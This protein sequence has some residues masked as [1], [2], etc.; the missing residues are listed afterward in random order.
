MR[1]G[2]ALAL[3]AAVSCTTLVAAVAT[4]GDDHDGVVSSRLP[5]PKG[6]YVALGDS[7]TA[8]PKVPSQNEKPAGCG[9]SDQ[10]YPALVAEGLGLEGAGFRDVSCSGATIDDLFAPQSTDHGANPAQLS[11]V[12]AATQMITLGIG[13]NDIGFS[14]MI[15]KCVKAGF[16]RQLEKRVGDNEANDAPCRQDYVF[17]DTDAVRARIHVVGARIS[18]VLSDIERLA[19]RAQVYVVGYPSTLPAKGGECE[20]LM[21]LAPGDLSFLREKEQQLNTVLRDKAQAAGAVY[22]DTYTPSV[23]RDACAGRDVRWIE[24]LIPEVPVAAVHPNERGE[25]GM[26]RAVLRAAGA[27]G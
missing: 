13:G 14:S 10:N 11:A 22:V 8:G 2:T 20:Q 21:D 24:P 3:A 17:G 15:S 26:A 25:R 7:Y 5:L 1:T 4:T 19:P 16:G 18:V 23:G 27:V 9:R 12:S 6:P